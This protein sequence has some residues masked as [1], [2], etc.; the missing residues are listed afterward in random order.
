MRIT[1]KI[2]TAQIK[3]TIS[4]HTHGLQ[5]S[6]AAIASGK[7]INKPSDDPVGTTQVIKQRAQIDRID[8]LNRNIDD[9][10]G[11]LNSTDTALDGLRSQ[12]V[13]TKEIALAQ[14]NGTADSAVRAS[15]VKEVAMILEDVVGLANTE[16]N[17]RF[18]FAG[19][20]TQTQPFQLDVSTVTYHGD[21]GK[22]Q[23]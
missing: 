7:R 15:A 17:G 4:K 5:K 14:A 11:F 13:H 19:R 16:F 23:R 6:Q 22:I 9:G 18:I 12:L 10:L 3:D 8:Q 2:I 21:E 20:K 1:N